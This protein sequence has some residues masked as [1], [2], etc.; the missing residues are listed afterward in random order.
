[1]IFIS[2]SMYIEA[3]PFI[4][5]LNLKKDL[6]YCKFQVFKNEDIVLIITGTGKVISAVAVTYLF[7]KYKLKSTDIFINIGVC[8][9]K[10]E[11]IHI[12]DIFLCNKIIDYDTKKTFYPDML[13]KHPFKEEN[14]ETVSEVNNENMEIKG[15]LVDME[16]SGIYEAALVF[17]QSQQVFFIKIVSDH[18]KN[19]KLDANSIF[20]LIESKSEQIINWI[21]DIKLAF[22][23]KQ[24]ILDEKEQKIA[25][26]IIEKLRLTTTMANQL[27]QLLK[28]YK[29]RKGEFTNDISMY[30]GIE[31]KSKMERMKY[32]EE[33]KGKII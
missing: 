18:L 19:E 23:Y 6:E 30:T 5:K 2:T 22:S 14:I 28:Y 9:A 16:A 1:M 21:K 26:C 27:K 31:C 4:K 12:G 24:N 8:G 11:K 7:S 17:L 13:L 3:C 32:F 10:N 20:N 25:S 33:L 15:Q 29:L